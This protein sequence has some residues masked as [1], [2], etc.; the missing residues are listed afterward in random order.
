LLFAKVGLL[1]VL[2]QHWKM[3][4]MGQCRKGKFSKPR[5]ITARRGKREGES[6][7]KRGSYRYARCA[8]LK[9]FL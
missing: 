3:G 9:I 4:G 7:G 2:I 1:G 8:V 6:T 5:C